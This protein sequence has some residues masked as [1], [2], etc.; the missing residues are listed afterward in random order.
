MSAWTDLL[1]G[2]PTSAAGI[3]T[4]ATVLAGAAHRSVWVGPDPAGDRARALSWLRDATRELEA[5][6]AALAT[7]LDW[8]LAA[9]AD[10]S[11]V[12]AAW[13]IDRVLPA[14]LG[15]ALRRVLDREGGLREIRRPARFGEL[16]VALRAAVAR[17]PGKIAG[18]KPILQKANEECQRLLRAATDRTAPPTDLRLAG[19][20]DDGIVAWA[21]E[22]TRGNRVV[23]NSP[24][25]NSLLQHLR[26]RADLVREALLVWPRGD[27]GPVAVLPASW[28]AQLRTSLPL[29]ADLAVA[30]VQDAMPHP[31]ARPLL[32]PSTPRAALRERPADAVGPC[33][34]LA[35]EAWAEDPDD[36]P[37]W[38]VAFAEQVDA[39][40]E[41]LADREY[42][43]DAA[44]MLATAREALESLDLAAARDWLAEAD[45]EHA[46]TTAGSQAERRRARASELSA[47]LV[48][49]RLPTPAGG[50]DVT[51]WAA[52]VDAAWGE[53]RQAMRSDAE[54]LVAECSVLR[55]ADTQAVDAAVDEARALVDRGQL[56]AAR[57]VLDRART[58]LDLARRQDDARIGDDLA[59][60]RDRV[61]RLSPRNR[62]PALAALRRVAAR[63]EA[64]L[65]TTPDVPALAGLIAGLEARTPNLAAVCAED[66]A[67]GLARIAWVLGGV[68]APGEEPRGPVLRV[69]G[70]RVVGNVPADAA[71]RVTAW[72]EV[73]S[74][75]ASGSATGPVF[76]RG[77]GGIRGPFT[78]ANGQLAPRH[79]WCAVAAL[80]EARFAELFGLVELGGRRALVPRP[81]D[82]PE[83]LQVGGACQDMLD[84]GAL[85]RWLA[86]AV[87]GAPPPAAIERWLA[88][89]AVS[90]VPAPIAAA[91]L[92]RMGSLLGTTTLLAN[93]R[94]S[95]I[96]EYL[97]AD[98]GQAA[99]A[100]AAERLVA[101][102][103]E[104]LRESVERQRL[105]LEASLAGVRAELDASRQA[106]AA[107][108]QSAQARLRAL[109]E[110]VGAAEGL[111]GDVKIRLLAELGLGGGIARAPTAG[112]ASPATPLQA[113]GFTATDTPDLGTLVRDLAGHTWDEPDV[114]NLLLSVATGRW[115]LLA[116][117]PGVGKSTFVRSVLARLGHGP[118]TE[119]Y[120]ELVV[121]RDWQDDAALFGFWH[122][123]ERAWTP[124][125]EG[126]V[127]QLLRAVDDERLGH[128][129]LWPVLVEELNLASPEYYLARPISAFESATPEI[130]LYDAALAPIN[131][132][133]YPASFPVADA[134]RMVATVNV[135]DTVERLSPRFLS[136]ASVIWIE[137][138]PDAAPWRPEDDAPR[139]RVRWT[140]LRG[141]TE[142][143]T[144]DLGD[145]G[146]VVRFLQQ[147]RIPG[148]P[149]IRTQRA[150]G[151]YL[152]AARGVLPSDDAEDLQVLQRI[153]PPIRGTGPRWRDLLDRL[154]DL[155]E[156]RGWR[157]SAERTRDIRER[158]EELGDWYD[159]FHA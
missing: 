76:L 63:R 55:E 123:T 84:D 33:F 6:H 5:E 71:G 73:L 101:H 57:A 156:R 7:V 105:D 46:R 65:D 146:E 11:E 85:A 22:V 121:R 10:A 35:R 137:P 134:V 66:A 52:A 119:R 154:G 128:G 20:D 18:D 44:T 106:A 153:L 94:E 140:A 133:R 130:R 82:L 70:V 90:G 43:G 58:L 138:R 91:R 116:G 51:A 34:R 108:E 126:F 50:S 103:L 151:R 159:F 1:R 39:L 19:I 113:A 120:L 37:T 16:Q 15:D 80:P 32:L 21:S 8:W 118:G 38:V 68:P 74:G 4:A 124:S 61:A 95:A 97:A 155:L 132:A 59:A 143:G 26:Y 112:P 102:D 48:A 14:P 67:G 3:V 86:H 96:A 136:R 42:A 62:A 147:A 125:S 150:I 13:K 24:V 54:R 12:H 98:A 17:N 29:G 157:R 60:L 56:P 9:A 31:P 139:H 99:L 100:A 78:M 110:E 149:T 104:R 115:T 135:D 30:L 131:A 25:W 47:Q 152:G 41:H 81:P 148:A 117:L 83:L 88:S 93:H 127:E 111:L 40:D 79:A 69:R 141:L 36:R 27:A 107:E 89:D 45:I 28:E 53:A 2:R 145:I 158:G 75:P 129:G 49:L 23:P 109:R 87:E 122:P 144:T 72:G 114:A 64:D 92:S 142:R 77:D